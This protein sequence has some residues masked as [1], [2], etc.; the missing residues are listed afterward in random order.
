M[1][2]FIDVPRLKFQRVFPYTR[3]QV[4]H[5]IRRLRA[6]AA[7]DCSAFQ[8]GTALTRLVAVWRRPADRKQTALQRQTKLA[9]L[10]VCDEPARAPCEKGA[11]GGSLQAAGAISRGGRRAF[12]R[13]SALC[14]FFLRSS[15]PA[16]RRRTPGLWGACRPHHPILHGILEN[17]YVALCMSQKLGLRP[18]STTIGEADE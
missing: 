18:Q 17:R 8:Q 1:A 11:G 6:M 9:L 4:P 16:E 2:G 12:F 5:P 3:A 10:P 7:E 15:C 13:R 14:K